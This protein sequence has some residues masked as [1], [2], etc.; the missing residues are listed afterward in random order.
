MQLND[1]ENAFVCL[2]E[3]LRLKTLDY[4]D[5]ADDDVAEIQ[6]HLGIIWKRKRKYEEALKC[7]E[8]ALKIKTIHQTSESTEKDHRH[9]MSCL[10]GALEAVSELYGNQHLN[11]AKLLHQKGNC[12]G[13]KKEHSLAIEAYVETLRIY[14]K[15]YGDSHLSVANTLF[16]LGV[17]LNEKGSP[18]KAIRCFTKAIRITKSRLGDDHLDGKCIF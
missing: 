3:S 17:S 12:H 4:G 16:N 13:A 9:L 15:E 7:F 5:D 8:Q 11:Y 14:K 6:R 2:D 10:D 18:D 1:N